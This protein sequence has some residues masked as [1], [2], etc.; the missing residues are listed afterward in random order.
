[1]TMDQAI[2]LVL[3]T[4]DT[5]KGGETMIPT[6]PAYRLGDLATAMGAKMNVRGL[7]KYEKLHESM[8]EGNSSE[9]ARRM[10]VDELRAVL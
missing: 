1:M 9:H 7:P 6:L 4:I 5:M 10:T 3:W 2:D 8:C